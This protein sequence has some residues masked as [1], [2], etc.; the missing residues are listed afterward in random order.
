MVPPS[1]PAAE[2]PQPHLHPPVNYVI[3]A[4]LILL[5]VAFGAGWTAAEKHAAAKKQEDIAAE[6]R[7]ERAS[8]DKTIQE[9]VDLEAKYR[10]AMAR[11]PVRVRVPATPVPAAGPQAACEGGLSREDREALEQRLSK[12]R[13]D[14]LDVAHACDE[15]LVKS[16]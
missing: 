1:I 7:E 5:P 16:Q 12:L 6:V 2:V 4:L 11:G 8:H 13:A 3:A 10:A 14:V 15:A 9:L